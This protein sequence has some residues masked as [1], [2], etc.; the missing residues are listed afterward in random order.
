M[1]FLNGICPGK[2]LFDYN[3]NIY[4]WCFC[5]CSKVTMID[6]LTRR[7]VVLFLS[8]CNLVLYNWLLHFCYIN[9]QYINNI[10]LCILGLF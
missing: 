5:L 2:S 3:Q 10:V 4:D 8:C 9:V 6:I 1:N 7:I